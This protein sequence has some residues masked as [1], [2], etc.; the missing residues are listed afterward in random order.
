M[1]P[2][3]AV[4][5]VGGVGLTIAHEVLKWLTTSTPEN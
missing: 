4:W 1:D 2:N 5:Y 3:L